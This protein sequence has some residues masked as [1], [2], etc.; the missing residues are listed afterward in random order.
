MF[1]PVE[2]NAR[3][4]LVVSVI[5]LWISCGFFLDAW[6]HG[7]VPVETFFTPYH[8]V[9][10]SGMLALLIVVAIYAARGAVPPSYRYPLLG[11]PIFIA[12]GFGDLLW[13][14]FLGIEE[15]IDALLSP[16]HQGL[17]L[18][19]F[20]ISAGP[21]VSALRNRS[22]LRTLADQLPLIF[23]L[24][25][26]IEL[27]HFGTAYAFDPGAGRMNAPPAIAP[28]TPDYLTAI[29]LGYYK[30]G[31][32]VLVVLF[33]STIMAG[34][35]LFAGTRF[36]LRPGS[37]TLMY[38]L[39]NFAAAAAFTNDTPL[40]ATVIGMSIAAGIV[41][42]AIVAQLRPSPERIRAYRLLGAAVPAS[43][44]ATYF[45]IT[46]AVER[47]WWD[48]NVMLGAIIWAGVIGFGLTLLSQPRL[49]KA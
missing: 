24:A 22:A 13:H 48:W 10:Y 17:G 45:V 16:T 26:W 37:L 11:I 46:A 9:F 40:L 35:A 8:G 34:F 18:G 49:Q 23:A 3:F 19:I 28:F 12:A 47:V 27:V 43:Y 41:G 36:P 15:G 7:H 5:T 1:A 44:F 14:H 33:Q 25:T 2:R 32:G 38:L 21:I 6:A 39:G 30:S 4:D 42:D 20:F 31:M 29:A